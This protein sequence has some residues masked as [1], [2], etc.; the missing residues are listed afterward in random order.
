MISS[1]LRGEIA[2]SFG[3]S[4]RYPAS[5]GGAGGEAQARCM[6][7]PRATRIARCSNG[8]PDWRLCVPRGPTATLRL[9]ITPAGP[10]DVGS[11]DSQIL[12]PEPPEGPRPPRHL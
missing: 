6:L 4:Q 10:I 9:Q 1:D 5:T 11:N 8:I 2:D 3:I 7:T 12:K